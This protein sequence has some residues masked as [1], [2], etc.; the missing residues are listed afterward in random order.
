MGYYPPGAIVHPAPNDDSYI[1]NSDG[2]L[3]LYS[4]GNDYYNSLNDDFDDDY[5]DFDDDFDDD[6]DDS[7]DW[8]E[9]YAMDFN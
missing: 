7:D 9:D 4:R 5:D 8:D 3:S 1:V 2:S 6:Y